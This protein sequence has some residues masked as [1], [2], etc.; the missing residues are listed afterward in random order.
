MTGLERVKAELMIHAIRND[1]FGYGSICEKQPNGYYRTIVDGEQ[2]FFSLK[3]MAMD[4]DTLDDDEKRL[5]IED[6]SKDNL[7]KDN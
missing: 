4:W 3:Q 6:Y 1:F 7:L 5:I 2:F